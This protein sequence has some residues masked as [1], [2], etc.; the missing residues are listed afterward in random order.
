MDPGYSYY[1]SDTS[2]LCLSDLTHWN[3]F[4]VEVLKLVIIIMSIITK[5]L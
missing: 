2:I 3:S 4:S 5:V 1:I